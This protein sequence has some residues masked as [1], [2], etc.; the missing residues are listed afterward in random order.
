MYKDAIIKS[1][2]RYH[3][4]EKGDGGRV[5]EGSPFH[6]TCKVRAEA[7][8]SFISR[9]WGRSKEKERRMRSAWAQEGWKGREKE[10]RRQNNVTYTD[11]ES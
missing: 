10:G 2:N 3:E 9:V 5:E 11:A 6:N 7:V 8:A 4:R 1:I